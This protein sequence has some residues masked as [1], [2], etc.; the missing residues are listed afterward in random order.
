M[1]SSDRLERLK[2]Q[3]RET[4]NQQRQLQAQKE[5]AQ[6]VVSKKKQELQENQ[7]EMTDFIRSVF[8][9]SELAAAKERELLQ[10]KLDRFL[11]R[12]SVMNEQLITLNDNLTDTTALKAVYESKREELELNYQNQKEALQGQIKNLE[13]RLEVCKRE[14]ESLE[15]DIII[16][17]ST[18]EKIVTETK[19][20]TFWNEFKKVW[21]DKCFV[22]VLVGFIALIIGGF[23]GWGIF[24]LFENIL[25]FIG[26]FVSSIF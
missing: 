17:T 6:E 15:K 14:L 5:N 24:T 7:K 3:V 9:Q 2:Q 25:S 8:G 12:Q 22:F 20:A 16:K 4:S 13:K 10:D 1:N 21:I 26:E 11:H 19:K 23:L 18:F